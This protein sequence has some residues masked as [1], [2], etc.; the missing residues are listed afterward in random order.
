MSQDAPD[1]SKMYY[2]RATIDNEGFDYAFRN[3][4]DFSEVK[5][6]KFHK[7]RK[8]YLEAYKDLAEY[9]EYDDE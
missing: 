8:A 4:H 9:V 2:V 1:R 3:Y 6:E 5:D 7:L